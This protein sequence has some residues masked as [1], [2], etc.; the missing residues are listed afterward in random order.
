V[1]FLG[2]RRCKGAQWV[3]RAFPTVLRSVPGASLEIVGDG[4]YRPTLERLSRSLG[5]SSRVSFRG[6]V[7][8][9]GKIAALN[10]AQVAAVPSP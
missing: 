1:V 6:A 5:I 9:E 10:A 2:R 4:P 3:L 8:H 7:S